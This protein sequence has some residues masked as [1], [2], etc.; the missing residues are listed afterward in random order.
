MSDCNQYRGEEIANS[1]SHGVGLLAAIA[2]MPVLIIAAVS[3]GHPAGIVGAS[4][5]AANV[6]LGSV[7]DRE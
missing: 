2:A 1:V 3:R 7:I 5:F 6:N 4:V